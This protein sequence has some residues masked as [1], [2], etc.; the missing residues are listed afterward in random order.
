MN[1]ES[2]PTEF[3]R[4]CD[5]Q[6]RVNCAGEQGISHPGCPRSC[7]ACLLRHLR[8]WEW[9][10]HIAAHFRVDSVREAEFLPDIKA[11]LDHGKVSVPTALDAT[12]Q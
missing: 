9:N 6:G 3:H 12:Q 8:V 4:N 7:K 11:V 5:A 10:A 2:R 1:V